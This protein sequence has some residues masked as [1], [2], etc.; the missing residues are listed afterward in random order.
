M[1]SHQN[2]V[3]AFS[4]RALGYKSFI[5]LLT[6]ASCT[7]IRYISNGEYFYD[8][9]NIIIDCSENKTKEIRT[10]ERQ[11][12]EHIPGNNKKILGSRPAVWFHYA[13]GDPKKKVSIRKYVKKNLGTAPVFLSDIYPQLL[14]DT[15]ASIVDHAGYFR[16]SVRYRVLTDLGKKSSAATFYVSLNRRYTLGKIEYDLPGDSI[17]AS[18]L[19]KLP[20]GSLLKPGDPYSLHTIKSELIRIEKIF[21]NEGFFFFGSDQLIFKADSTAGNHTVDLKVC[22]KAKPTQLMR[23]AYRFSASRIY[24]GNSGEPN[25]KLAQW[26]MI[27]SPDHVLLYDP[28]ERVKLVKPTVISRMNNLKQGHPFSVDADERTRRHFMDL[29][30]LQAVRIR[31]ECAP[32]DSALIT[33]NIYLLL[34]KRKSLS[35]ELQ[36]VSKSNGT[37][38]PVASV[39][40]TNRNFLGGAEKFDLSVSGAYETQSS[41][42]SNGSLKAFELKLES[43]LII[44]RAL[45]PFKTDDYSG[46]HLPN[47]SVKAGIHFQDRIGYYTIGAFNASWGYRWHTGFS[48]HEFYPFELSYLNTDNLSTEFYQLLARNRSLA[49]SLQDQVIIGARYTYSVHTKTTSSG[50]AEVNDPIERPHL[51]FFKVAI[52]Q[53]GNVLD[54]IV[55]Q[56][57]DDAGRPFRILGSPYAQYV[58]GDISFRHYWQLHK[59][60]RVVINIIA[61]AGYAYGNAVTMPY[62]KQYSVGG[63]SSLRAF[64]ARSVG[65]GSYSR[66]H[67]PAYAEDSISFADQQGDIKLQGNIEYRFDIYKMF[68]GTLFVDS[69]NIWTFGVDNARLGS[70]FRSSTFYKQLAIGA[71]IGLRLDFGAFLLRFDT[72]MPLRRNDSGWVTHAIDFGDPAWR[73]ENIIFNIGLGYPF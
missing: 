43:S 26:E 11:L 30:L 59:H 32:F 27:A 38:G 64:P 42:T 51:L 15:L 47:T 55:R 14:A 18:I 39:T 3:I 70:V 17:Y 50:P 22:F 62:I 72:G 10:L 60:H 63:A 29:N 37:I 65:P 7:A 68:K 34:K 2:E 35:T 8:N 23:T 73:R 61:A 24:F 21:R 58:K 40:F 71:G 45:I 41:N 56:G 57:N 25:L 36:F 44:G 4:M 31:Y 9:T 1:N 12:H 49:I 53:S 16:S 19:G 52:E 69:G 28:R 13:M 46:L 20:E 54:A 5:V 66:E 67:D 6:C 48:T 33:P